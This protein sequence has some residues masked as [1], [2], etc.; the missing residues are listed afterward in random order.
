MASKTSRELKAVIAQIDALFP[1]L[2]DKP[3]KQADILCEK[4]STLKT[5]L[6]LEADER[7]IEQDAR[8]KEL[9]EQ[10][11]ADTRR[12]RELEMENAALCAR[13]LPEAI[14]VPDPGTRCCTSREYSSQRP[15]RIR[16]RKFQDGTRAGN[17][18]NPCHSV[19]SQRSSG[20]VRPAPRLHV[21]RVRSNVDDAQN[22]RAVELRHL[23]GSV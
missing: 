4:S 20:K 3:S 7:E 19:L 23:S 5:L 8:I 11:E 17:D 14:K 2:A 13:P 16:R 10:H 1:T 12:L 18:G 9:V 15:A 21:C 6:S 22:G